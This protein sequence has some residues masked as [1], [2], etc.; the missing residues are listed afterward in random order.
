MK[1]KDETLG[2]FE[3]IT[4]I[5]VNLGTIISWVITFITAFALMVQPTPI[6]LPGFFELGKPYKLIFLI[7]ILFGYLQLLR[8]FWRNSKMTKADS[9]NNF[10]SYLYGSIFKLKRPFVI[11]G[12]AVIFIQLYQVEPTT[13][14]IFLAISLLTCGIIAYAMF[15]EDSPADIKKVV[16]QIDDEFNKRWIKRVKSQLHD[17]GYAFTSDFSNLGID[18]D[19]VNWAI[20]FYFNRYEF[21]QDLILTKRW[22]KEQFEEKLFLELR[23]NHLPTRL[24][25]GNSS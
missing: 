18:L 4:T 10:S 12:F 25:D 1:S 6:S 24:K 7:S 17:K 11:I 3:T 22:Y 20:E 15:D 8:R 19:E 21:E 16:W 23:Y 5:I 13:T 14:S 9:E 2:K